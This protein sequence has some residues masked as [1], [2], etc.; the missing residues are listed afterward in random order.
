MFDVL[1]SNPPKGPYDAVVAW[2]VLEHIY[3]LEGALKKVH[4]LLRPAG[5]FMSKSIFA[6]SGSPHEAIHLAQHAK[7]GDVKVL[8]ELMERVGFKFIGQL[9]PSRTS[10]L[11]RALGMRYAV[12]GICI[13]P[14]LKHGGNFLVHER[15]GDV[16]AG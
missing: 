7:Y 8:N 12:A 3:D 6:T 4:S 9:K 16:A 10:R 13:M 2:D 14:R 1:S 5:W 11:L 15:A